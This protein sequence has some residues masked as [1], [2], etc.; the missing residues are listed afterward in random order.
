MSGITESDLEYGLEDSRHGQTLNGIFKQRIDVSGE[1]S[2]GDNGSDSD[3]VTLIIAIPST[4]GD[5]SDEETI[6]NDVKAIF[7]SACAEMGGDDTIALALDDLYDVV[8]E[9]VDSEADAQ[10]VSD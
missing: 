8:V 1:N 2:D 7:G 4:S 6:L 9:T 10:R 5:G 3:T